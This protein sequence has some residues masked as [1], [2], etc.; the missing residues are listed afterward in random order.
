MLFM[1]IEHRAATIVNDLKTRNAARRNRR[2][3][4]TRYRRCKWINHYLKKGSNYKAESPRP[5]GWLPPSAKSIGDNVI[6]WVKRLRKLINITSCSFEA[7]R[8]DTQLMDNPNVSSVEYQYGTLYGYE[9]REY[10]LDK[11][12]HTCQYCGGESK[13]AVLEWEHKMPRS[14]GGSDSV[15][16][17]TLACH[18]CNQDKGAMTPDE[19]LDAVKQQQPSKLRDARIKGIQNVI[20]NKTRSSD[21]YCA[22]A[23]VTRRYVEQALFQMFGDVECSTGGRT[24]Y[25][26]TKLGLSKDHHYDALCVGTV[27]NDGYN[28]KTNGFYLY[29]KAIGRGNRFRSKINGCGIV[30]LKLSRPPKRIFGFQ[31]G[32]IVS[33]DVP[34]GKY[35]G[36]HIGRVMTRQRGYFDIRTLSGNLIAANFKYCRVLQRNNG[37]QY[38]LLGCGGNSS[39]QLN[40]RGSLPFLS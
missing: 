28:D 31:N 30:T 5:D 27:P 24:K 38:R 4:E 3:R 34:K 10:L 40:N 6:N 2:R 12:R 18:Q 16:N 25:N 21:R 32:D 14:R 22:W 11:Y 13:D 8:F 23:N 39:R 35:Q 15:K 9:V 20:E 29:A 37:Y 26:R 36:H 17:A 19:W 7:V 33:A 1:Q